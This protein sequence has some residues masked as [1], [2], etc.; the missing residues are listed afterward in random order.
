MTVNLRHLLRGQGLGMF[1]EAYFIFSIGGSL[2]CLLLGI[3]L[4]G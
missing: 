3:L 4:P 1:C 2:C